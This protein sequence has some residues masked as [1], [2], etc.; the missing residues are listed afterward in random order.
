MCERWRSSFENFYQDM[1]P[2]YKNGLSIDRI[3][4][5]GNYEPSN[6]RW[7]TPTEQHRN[8]RISKVFEINGEIKCLPEWCRIYGINSST[9]RHRL[10]KG[11]DLIPALTEKP[12]P[13]PKNNFNIRWNGL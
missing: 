2:G 1:I 7:A 5:N 10:A 13:K 12:Q 9:V 11:M 3:N 6:C 4:N 8:R